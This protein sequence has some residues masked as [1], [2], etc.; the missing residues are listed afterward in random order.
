M[1]KMRFCLIFIYL[2]GCKYINQMD[3]YTTEQRLMKEPSTL[4]RNDY[5]AYCLDGLL[6]VRYGHA[7]FYKLNDKGM[8]MKCEK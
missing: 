3:E 1:I 5:T 4:R 6:L 7:M 8:P 2:S